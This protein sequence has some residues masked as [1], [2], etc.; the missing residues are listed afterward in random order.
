MFFCCYQQPANDAASTEYDA[1][2][3]NAIDDAKVSVLSV[4]VR[5]LSVL[6]FRT[7]LFF[8][9]LNNINSMMSDPSAM[10][11]AQAMMGGGAGG[12]PD[13]GAMQNMMQNMDPS[14]LAQAQK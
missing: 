6:N 11:N 5:L 14:I 10:A 9:L 2:S 7:E 13:M 3:S 12:M 4:V 1:K 8:S